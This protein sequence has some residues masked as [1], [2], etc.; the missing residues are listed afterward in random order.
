MTHPHIHWTFDPAQLVVVGLYVV[1]YL[2]RFIQ[3]RKE[4]GGRGAGPLQLL[5]FSGAVIVM[6]VA[7][8]SPVDGLGE[9]YLFSMH[10]VQH[11]LIGDIAPLLVL[12]SLSR[13][14]MRPLTR[15]LM[16]VERALGPFAHPATGIA[17]WLVLIYVWHIPAMYD[18]ALNHDAI[19]ALEHTCFFAAGIALWWP[20][21]QPVPMRRRLKGLSIFAYLLVAKFSAGLLGVFFTWSHGV[22]Y[23]YYEHVPRIWGLSAVEDQ[24]LG[25]AIMMVEQS[26]VLVVAFAILFIRMLLQSE[27]DERRRERFEDPAPVA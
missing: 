19:H 6:L 8:V 27:E 20:L 13:V 24:N 11:I 22:A 16:A 2:R 10:M 7:L 18:A 26:I 9:D 3:A 15:R 21:I 1:L 5:A 17:I 4:A 23:P 25:G 14:I 12:L